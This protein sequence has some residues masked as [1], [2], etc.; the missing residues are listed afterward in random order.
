MNQK[1]WNEA[2][3]R[4]DVHPFAALG[5]ASRDAPI[6]SFPVATSAS[7]S[8]GSVLAAFLALTAVA[9]TGWAV[10]EACRDPE[11]EG[12]ERRARALAKRGANVSADI[13]GWRRPPLINGHIPDI[14]ARFRDGHE[15]LYEYENERSVRS[16]HARR[17]DAAF[18][19]YAAESPS[20]SYRSVVVQ[21][22]RGG[23]G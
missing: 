18:R 9:V 11:R 5:Q 4:T 6:N 22:G 3:A 2:N 19:A 10:Y 8:S 13:P 14:H 7:S 1:V 23:H 17:Q 21:G 16:T 12:I 15:K 20:R